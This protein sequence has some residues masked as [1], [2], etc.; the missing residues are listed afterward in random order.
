[1][2][3]SNKFIIISSVVCTFAVLLVIVGVYIAA[4]KTPPKKNDS[5]SQEQY[6]TGEVQ[7]NISGPLKS[8]KSSEKYMLRL[9]NDKICGYMI[10]EDG[11]LSLWNS[12]KVPP[13]LSAQD[14]ATLEKGIT[15]DTFEKLCLYFE[16]YA[17]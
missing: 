3:L 2:K 6:K 5:L 8:T 1:M 13:D 12:I 14:K 17:S 11:S 9:E 7:N 15:T 16:S 4:T 10:L